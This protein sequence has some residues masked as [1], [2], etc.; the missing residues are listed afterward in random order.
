MAGS[1]AGMMQQLQGSIQRDPMGG[2]MGAGLLNQVSQGVGGM[3]GGATG[4]DPMNYMNQGG[5]VLEAQ[6]QMRQLDLNTLE[7]LQQAANIQQ[8]AG[9]TELAQKFRLAAEQK[10]QTQMSE[11]A[12]G[13]EQIAAESRKTEAAKIAMQRGDRE[14]HRAIIAGILSPEA[15][16]AQVMEP[17][18]DRAVSTLGEDEVLIDDRTGE[19]IAT[20]PKGDPAGQGSPSRF[21]EETVWNHGQAA[22]KAVAQYDKATQL[23]DKF[24]Q[25]KQNSVT[26]GRGGLLASGYETLAKAVGG[27]DQISNLR[28]EYEGI[29][30]T[31]AMNNLPPGSASDPDVQLALS[32]FPPKTANM[33]T[34]ESWLRGYAKLQEHAAI[35]NNFM[36]NWMG[37]NRSVFG[38]HEAWRAHI[39]K[40]NSNVINIGDLPK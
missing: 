26:D 33:A 23:A 12:T 31:Q 4:T 17:D 10:R 30:N 3:M 5:K 32:E 36:S 22:N 38:A 35:Y 15:Y 21:L 29:K 37:Q 1:L 39:V 7:G 11:L 20:G 18:P 2:Q 25:A 28:R 27:D 40:S 6:D 9:N 19:T 14:A 16:I 13:Q 24:Q 34:I 8:A